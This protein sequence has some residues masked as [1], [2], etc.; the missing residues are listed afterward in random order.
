M[1]QMRPAAQ[2][3]QKDKDKIMGRWFWTWKRLLVTVGCASLMMVVVK[4]ESSTLTLYEELDKAETA[5]R[6]SGG[7][8]PVCRIAGTRRL[9]N[10][11]QQVC[12]QTLYPNM[13]PI[14][15]GVAFRHLLW[16]GMPLRSLS[17][18]S[19]SLPEP[20]ADGGWVLKEDYNYYFD[21]G[22]AD[23]VLEIASQRGESLLELGGGMG[24]YKEYFVSSGLLSRVSAIDGAGNIEQLT[25][26]LIKRANLAAPQEL[27]P[28]DWVMTFEV[29]EHIPR[30]YE[31]IFLDNIT[32]HAKEGVILSWARPDQA[33]HSHV[34]CRSHEY[35]EQRMREKGFESRP[36]LAQN[37]R[38]SAILDQFQH[39]TLVFQRLR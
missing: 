7:F 31:G 30:E 22:T 12:A 15:A 6:V 11:F 37:I 21:K 2:G 5:L 28:H 38:D 9:T 10:L 33:G 24:C 16:G 29:G 20:L 1:V 25:R 4:R 3:E 39:N 36:D 17:C 13:V 23:A 19:N 32:R 35:I 18:G 8:A 34:N 26:G 27:E 14:D